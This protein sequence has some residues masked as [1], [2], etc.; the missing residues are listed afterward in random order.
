MKSLAIQEK[1][2]ISTYWSYWL[3][4]VYSTNLEKAVLS[5]DELKKIQSLEHIMLQRKNHML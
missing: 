5:L 4:N 3:N 2:M 1:E